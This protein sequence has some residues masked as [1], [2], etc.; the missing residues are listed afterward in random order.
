MIQS[1]TLLVNM[2][3]GNTQKKTSH[4]SKLAVYLV[5]VTLEHTFYNKEL[6]KNKY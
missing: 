6:L 3:Q 4:N 1:G 5:A 2:K